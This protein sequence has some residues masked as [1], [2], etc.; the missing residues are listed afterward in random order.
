MPKLYYFDI[1][2]SAEPIR[3]ALWAGK[4]KYEDVRLDEAKF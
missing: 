1:Y 4:H 2:G 3:M